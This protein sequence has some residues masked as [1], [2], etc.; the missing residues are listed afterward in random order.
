MSL[1]QIDHII[2]WHKLMVIWLKIGDVISKYFHGVGADTRRRN[3]ILYIE[4]D[5]VRV[6]GM[7]GVRTTFFIIF[8]NIFIQLEK[9]EIGWIGFAKR[10][11]LIKMLRF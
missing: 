11:F 3:L 7:E 10:L 4:V 6:E 8:I 9:T 1:S 5:G 2:Q